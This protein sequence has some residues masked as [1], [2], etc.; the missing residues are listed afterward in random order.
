[1]F[2]PQPKP[3]KREK[4][5]PKPLKRTPLNKTLKEKKCAEC[6]NKF[7][8]SKPLQTT[9]SIPCAIA[10]GKKLILKKE[11]TEWKEK[12]KVLKEKLKTLGDHQQELQRE[13]NKIA[14]I[15][16]FGYPCISCGGNGK[17]Q[18]GHYHTT[19]AHPAIRYNLFNIWIQD[20]YCNVELSANITKYTQGLINYFGMELKNYVETGLINEFQLLKLSKEEI[21]EKTALVREI[22]RRMPPEKKYSNQERIELRKSLNQEIG[23]YGTSLNLNQPA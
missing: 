19:Q 7:N 23:I 2:N 21:K 20:Y 15:I 12:K 11:K 3:P 4:A 5:K 17:P 13:I 1:M 22:I 6:K 18:A 9:C 16:D 10:Y 8:P 14:R